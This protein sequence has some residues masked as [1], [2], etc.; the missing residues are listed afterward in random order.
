MHPSTLTSAVFM[1]WWFASPSAAHS[2]TVLILYQRDNSAKDTTIF[3]ISLAV[4]AFQTRSSEYITLITLNTATI[5]GQNSFLLWV[6]LLLL[7]LTHEGFPYDD[8]FS[9][10]LCFLHVSM[11]LCIYSYG[12]FANKSCW[13]KVCFSQPHFLIDEVRCPR[14]IV[15]NSHTHCSLCAKVQF[16]ALSTHMLIYWNMTSTR[17]NFNHHTYALRNIN[18]NTCSQHF[19]VPVPNGRLSL[20]PALRKH[21]PLNGLFIQAIYWESQS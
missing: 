4:N 18:C 2:S 14:V 11:C 17:M 6:L 7:P 13:S 16:V 20:W 15:E 9:F 21:G 8:L 12:L 19:W 5:F 10:V 3:V 1:D